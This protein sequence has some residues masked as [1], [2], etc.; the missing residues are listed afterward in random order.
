[1]P[2]VE[3][4]DLL[5]GIGV[6]LTV[7]VGLG[8]WFDRWLYRRL[9]PDPFQNAPLWELLPIGVSLFDLANTPIYVNP[10]AQ[11][12]LHFSASA[13]GLPDSA[14]VPMLLEDI[15]LA[16]ATQTTSSRIFFLEQEK[17]WRRW[18]ITAWQA[19]TV[20]LVEDATTL[21]HAEQ[22]AHRMI[23]DLTHEIRTPVATLLTHVE[24][25]KLPHLPEETRA[26]SLA[27]M[28]GEGQRLEKLVQNITDLSRL[29]TSAAFELRPVDVVELVA[30]VLAQSQS[31]AVERQIRLI[32]HH[33]PLLPLAL[34]DRGRLKQLFLNLIENALKYCRAHDQ[35]EITLQRTER[36]ISVAIADNGPGIAE[37]HL[38]Y[39]TNRFYRIGGERVSG[40]GL[41]LAFVVEILRRHQSTLNISSRTTPPTGTT[42][43]FVLPIAEGQPPKG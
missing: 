42:F 35:V 39:I 32:L 17:Q 37:K 26:Q 40:N 43:S 4:R 27:F 13:N 12:L 2:S 19:Q 29:E 5:I 16:R 38:P 6:L 36:G 11:R 21:Q 1:M 28:Q 23:S 34:G 31:F 25:L 9:T 20:L 14:W 24:V 15:R 8:V 10:T 18:W 33:D 3:L 22:N 30:E 7:S 41:G